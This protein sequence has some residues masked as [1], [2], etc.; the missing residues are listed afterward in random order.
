MT[1]LED[2]ELLFM[3][4]WDLTPPFDLGRFI[5]AAR[6]VLRYHPSLCPEERDEFAD[7]ALTYIEMDA[8]CAR[9]PME[10]L[11]SELGKRACE[12]AL[13]QFWEEYYAERGI[14]QPG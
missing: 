7:F 14:S 1:A 2:A 12:R 5:H 8:A 13:K 10:D 6:E 11:P 4:T 9:F 3:E